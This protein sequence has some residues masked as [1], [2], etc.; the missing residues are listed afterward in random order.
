MWDLATI[1]RRNEV[2]AQRE[3]GALE[4]KP[5]DF[6]FTNRGSITILEPQNAKAQAHLDRCLGIDGTYIGKGLAIQSTRSAEIA[7]RLHNRGFNVCSG[8][9]S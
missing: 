1:V 3:V 8:L 9:L 5:L 6:I 2:A 7:R 4:Q